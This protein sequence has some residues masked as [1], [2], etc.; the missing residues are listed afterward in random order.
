MPAKRRWF[1]PENQARG[2]FPSNWARYKQLHPERAAVYKGEAWRARRAEQLAAHPECIVCGRKATHADHV[3]PVAEGGVDGPLQ[4]MCASHHRE[5]TLAE[6]HEG[7]KRAAAR[8]KNPG[9][10]P[11]RPSG[12]CPTWT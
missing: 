12:R 2:Q 9:A 8:R 10:A 4:S 11:E 7:M 1:N 5:K 6:S 3:L